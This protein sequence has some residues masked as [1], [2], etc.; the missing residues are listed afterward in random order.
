M[1]E[2]VLVLGATGL[3][4][5][6]VVR[7]LRDAGIAVRVLV[8]SEEKAH[9]L[10]GDSATI[11]AGDVR[12]QADLE[13]A[14]HGCDGVHISLDPAVEYEAAAGVVKLSATHPL[15]RI[16][17]VSGTTVAEQN[18]W[19]P[20]VNTKLKVEALLRDSGVPYTIFC[21]TWFMEMLSNFVREERAVMI[22]KHHPDYHWLAVDDFARMVTAAYQAEAAANKR[23][24]LHG[25]EAI[26]L[27]DA[28]LRYRDALAP[29]ITKLT[30]M[31]PQM[32]GLVARLTGNQRLRDVVPFLAYLQKVGELGDPA[33][34][35][36]VLG[37]PEITL[38]RWL[39]MRQ[40]T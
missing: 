22:G 13:R 33:E 34:A 8:R 20:M 7:H 9:R 18:R 10:L 23:F 28:I 31:S 4:G 6:A 26:S 2:T 37:A 35:N 1:I 39:E 12:D 32:A 21:P 16:T 38:D 27:K 29:E 19:F 17:Y 30:V 11:L 15:K 14:L 25:P 5:G 3:L 24:T 36:A 40:Q